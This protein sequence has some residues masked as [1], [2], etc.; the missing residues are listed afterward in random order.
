MNVGEIPVRVLNATERAGLAGAVSRTLEGRGFVP[1][2]T[3]N[4]LRK[5]DGHVRI[6]FG[7]DGLVQ[8][9]TLAN[10]FAEYELVLDNRPQTTVDVVLGEAFS[11]ETGIRPLLAP[12]LQP[13]VILTENA[14]CLPL[15]LVEPE[16]APRTL[17]AD[18]FAV[19]P[20]ATPSTGTEDEAD[21]GDGAIAD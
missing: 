7:P 8:A 9:Y 18:P 15:H 11:D 2:G 17:P 5:Y 14:P 3:G 10:Q 19:E 12:E 4:S 1:V 13:D 16:P 20:S 21:E 6:S